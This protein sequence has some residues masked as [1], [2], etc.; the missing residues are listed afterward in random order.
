MIHKAHLLRAL[1]ILTCVV[2]GVTEFFALQ[3]AHVANRKLRG[4]LP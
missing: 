3:R 1:A 4:P 2:W